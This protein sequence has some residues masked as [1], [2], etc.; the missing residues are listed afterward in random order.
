MNRRGHWIRAF[1]AHIFDAQTMERVVDPAIADLQVEAASPARYWAVFKVIACCLPEASMRVRVAAVL[2]LLTAVAVVALLETPA[3]MAASSQGVLEPAMLLYLIPQ[4]LSFALTLALTVWVVCQ[5]GGH[6]RSRR[7]TGFVIGAAVAVSA[8]SFVC[9]GWLTPEANQAYR[10][11]WARRGGFP[12]SPARGFTELTFGEARARLAT[13]L[14][15]PGTMNERDLH[16]LAVSYEGRLAASVAPIV[17]AV[18]ALLIAPWRWWARWP[19]AVA[20]CVAYP[21]YLLF[22]TESNLIA[23]DG[24]WFGSAAWYPLVA[25]AVPIVSILCGSVFLAR[26]STARVSA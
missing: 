25:L 23:I 7:V 18:F 2:S 3:L 21:G 11:A 19:A 20:V 1:A 6:A 16:F 13:A 26:T 9:H 17:F 14:R 4:A 8:V 15:N 12:A 5:F 24:I 22:L 10:V